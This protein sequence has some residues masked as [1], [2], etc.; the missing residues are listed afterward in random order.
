MGKSRQNRNTGPGKPAA[1]AEQQRRRR[2][3]IAGDY[4][5]CLDTAVDVIKWFYDKHGRHPTDPELR[6]AHTL[7]IQRQRDRGQR[8]LRK[9][10]KSS[11][12]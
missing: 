5:Q 9:Q 12:D 3:T 4:W 1:E 8:P 10:Q 7:Y 11:G 6:A 2:E